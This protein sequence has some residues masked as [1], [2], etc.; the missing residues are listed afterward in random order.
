MCGMRIRDAWDTLIGRAQAVPVRKSPTGTV[1]PARTDAPGVASRE[2]VSLAAVYRAVSIISNTVASMPYYVERDGKRIEESATPSVIRAP[3]LEYSRGDFV[4]A[5]TTSLALTGNAYF[6]AE[7][8]Y[9]GAPAQLTPLDPH[10]VQPIYDPAKRRTLYA[11]DGKTYGRERVG[12]CKLFTMPGTVTGLGPIQAAATDIRGA[13]NTRDYASKYFDAT[14]QPSGIITTDQDMTRDEARD[15][16][17]AYNNRDPETGAELNRAYNPARVKALPKG[18]KYQPLSV[19]PREAQWIEAR[20]FDTTSI[21]RLF[22]VPASL[23][24][25]AVEGNSQTYANV[26]QEWISFARFTL[27]QYTR[28]IEDELTRMT[29]RGQRVKFNYSGLLRSDTLTR[30]QAYQIALACGFQTVNEVR[31]LEDLPP[32]TQPAGSTTND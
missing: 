3:S 14:G 2:A 19:A 7:G 23:L 4:E 27:T 26:E 13:I 8:E 9:R 31:A 22:G 21:A 29:V 24:L 1:P 11:V 30:Y 32:L 15:I 16:I 6:L 18:M 28:T 5:L 17:A 10:L 25:A 20:Q 12:H